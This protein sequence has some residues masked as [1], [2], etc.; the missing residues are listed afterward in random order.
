M[1][2]STALDY[3]GDFGASAARAT[4]LEAA[5][6]DLIWVAEAYGFDAVSLLGYLAASTERVGLGTGILNVYSR[7]PA[8]LAQTAA[9]LDA[10]SRGRFTLGIGASGPQVVEG[11]H[12]VPFTKPLSR[13]R[14]TIEICRMAW[15][16]ERLQHSGAA[17]TL[18]LPAERGTGL[19]RPLKLINTPLRE[20]IPIY[21]AG[22]GPK[23]VEMCA[24]L[25]DGWLPFLFVPDL[26]EKVWGRALERGRAR[27][28]PELGPLDVVAGGLLAIGNHQEAAAVR[29]RARP[30]AALYIG[31]MGAKGANFYNDLCRA[32]GFEK[33][34]EEIQDLYLSGSK[35][36]AEAAVPEALLELSSLC[37]DAVY[38]AERVAAYREAGVTMLNVTPVG[39]DP[40]RLLADL[41]D[42]I[43]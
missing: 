21:V 18:P 20:R 37:G 27:R 24:E 39:P 1:R 3:A 30:L 8:L 13:V 2:I 23:S 15:R 10:L 6:V 7:T 14:D 33:E 12:G 38:V 35:R 22:L 32:Y 28:S 4:D 36:E 19:G 42:I 11:F 5:G 25:A 40:A 31:G 29:E 9:G 16:R 41:R 43:G 34:A 26:A 17:L